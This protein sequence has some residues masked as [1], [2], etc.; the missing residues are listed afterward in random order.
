MGRYFNIL[1]YFTV[2]SNGKSRTHPMSFYSAAKLLS[3]GNSY[4]MYVLALSPTISP[5]FIP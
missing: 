1:P 4:Y 2:I 3:N 5:N